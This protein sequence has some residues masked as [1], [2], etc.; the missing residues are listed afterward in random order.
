MSVY[1]VLFTK[2]TNKS[3]LNQAHASLNKRKF[4]KTC[5][6]QSLKKDKTKILMTN[7]SPNKDRN[8][9]RMLSLEHS[10]IRLTCIKR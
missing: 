9:C 7:G 5:V 1:V 4:S 3:C 2:Y 8:Y 6:K 10:A